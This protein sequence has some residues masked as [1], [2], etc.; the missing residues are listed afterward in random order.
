MVDTKHTLWLKVFLGSLIVTGYGL[1]F[2]ADSLIATADKSVVRVIVKTPHGWATGTGFVV[3]AD[4]L[5]VTNHHVIG[6][7]KDIRILIKGVQGDP[8]QLPARV[9]WESIDFDLA[10]LRVPGLVLPPLTF[11][12]QLPD[13][14]TQVIAIGYPGIADRDDENF[15][16]LAESTVSQGVIGR[17]INSNWHPG[18]RYLNI[19][20]H[21]AAIN[22]GNSGGPLLNECGHVVGVNTQKR[23]GELETRGENDVVVNQ[24]DGIF[25]AS[26]ASVLLDA[27]KGQGVG[28]LVNSS[29]CLS[30]GK[31]AGPI[32]PE[33]AQL[34]GSPQLEDWALGAGVTA[35]ILMALGALFVAMRKNVA[36]VESFT[37]YR[38]RTN[39]GQSNAIAAKHSITLALRGRGRDNKLIELVLDPNKYFKTPLVVGRDISSCDLP[40]PDPTI[41]RRHASITLSQAGWMISDL[42]STNGTWLDSQ[43]IHD[44]AVQLR[45][46]QSLIFGKVSLNIEVPRP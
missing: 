46:G 27:L 23:L 42:G 11:S 28:V 32:L 10:V 43:P 6:D 39:R 37:Q 24:S 17:A 9:L 40:I 20:Q 1:S 19:L 15:N 38:R 3:S 18:G 12:D 14:G 2:S 7:D 5:V 29:T 45:P 36:V 44:K 35:A 16:N 31:L 13:K 33:R 34:P 30:G 8:K 21:G 25:F 41:S 22:R 26:H 4:E